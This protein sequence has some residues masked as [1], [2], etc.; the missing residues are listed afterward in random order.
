LTG[1]RSGLLLALLAVS[2]CSGG[3]TPPQLAALR[4]GRDAAT[5]CRERFHEESQTYA[6]CARYV[7]Q[8]AS[9]NAGYQD[10]RRLGALYTGWISADMVGQQGDVPADRAARQ[11]LGEALQLQRRLGARDA[12][13]CGVAGLPCAT[14]DER[15]RE[16]L[17]EQSSGKP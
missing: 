4:E 16:L 17:A 9:S 5:P 14:M 12:D 1:V 7:A 6:D 2:A 13:L 10:W 3:A 11:L 15:R 8:Q